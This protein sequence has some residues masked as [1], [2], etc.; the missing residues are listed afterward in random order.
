MIQACEK[1]ASRS[2]PA[3]KAIAYFRNNAHHM[4]YNRFRNN[5]YMIGSGTVENA[6]KQIVTQRIKRS[7][8]QWNR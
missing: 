5:G 8:V 4:E 1:L 3:S 2:V 6:C 7:G